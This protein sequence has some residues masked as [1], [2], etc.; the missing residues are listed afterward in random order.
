M[1]RGLE[2]G[3]RR[4]RVECFRLC[5]ALTLSAHN[6]AHK[7]I[8]FFVVALK[9]N[10]F[11]FVSSK[12]VSTH[13]FILSHLLLLFRFYRFYHLESGNENRKWI[14]DVKEDSVCTVSLSLQ[15]YR[16]MNWEVLLADLFTLK[17]TTKV[18][19]KRPSS[20]NSGFDWNLFNRPF[21]YSVRSIS[22]ICSL[23]GDIESLSWE[24]STS[25]I[26]LHHPG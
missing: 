23:L 7:I 6:N 15:W 19:Y 11:K 18:L 17:P 2:L 10:R 4:R 25:L 1:I 24:A 14:E 16:R 12:L 21:F 5:C 3:K 9:T 8:C 22:Q 20:L 13:S 26:V